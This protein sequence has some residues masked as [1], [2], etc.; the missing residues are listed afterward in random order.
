MIFGSVAAA[1]GL[2]AGGGALALTGHRV[3][4]SSMVPTLT[5]G[6]LIAAN[7]FDHHPG[8]FDVV[9]LR[10]SEDSA[11]SQELV[12][13]IIGLPGDRI[14]IVPAEDAR[15]P[16][17]RVSPAGSGRWSEVNPRF[18]TRQWLSRVE[19]CAPDGRTVLRPTPSVVPPGR[20]F[21]LGDNPDA[22]IDSRTFGFVAPDG[23]RGIVIGRIWPLARLP[24]PRY[25]L[26]P[27]G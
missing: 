9:V 1:L 25:C 17:I 22:S 20:Y 4:G 6:E 23:V 13:R 14:E 12:K 16:T 3:S 8:R 11:G 19:C 5:D 27:A 15:A 26:D 24:E 21:V 18:G 7:P 2:V 10:A